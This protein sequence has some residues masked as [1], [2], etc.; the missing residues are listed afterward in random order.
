MFIHSIDEPDS[1]NEIRNVLMPAQF[2]PSLRG[3][4]SQLEHHCQTGLRTAVPFRFAVP[5]TDRG[6]R[7]FDRIGCANVTPVHGWKIEER[8]QHIA[9]FLQAF[10]RL[11]V[12]RRP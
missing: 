6:E 4:L 8:Q 5:Q 7:A 2:T 12:L 9:V 3:T 10:D 11:F 1:S